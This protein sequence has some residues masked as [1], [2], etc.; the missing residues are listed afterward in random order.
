MRVLFVR[1]G[2]RIVVDYAGDPVNI[3]QAAREWKEDARTGEVV[4]EMSQRTDALSSHREKFL[5]EIFE[6]GRQYEREQNQKRVNEAEDI[7]D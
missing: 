6:L 7:L 5:E 1:L 2:N 3:G 4:A